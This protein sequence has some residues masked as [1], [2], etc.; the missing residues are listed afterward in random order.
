MRTALFWVITQ[1]VVV[2]SYRGFGKN[3]QSHLQG[4]KFLTG[5]PETPVRNYHYSLHTQPRRAQVIFLFIGTEN[6]LR[7]VEAGG[8]DIAE[9]R[10]YDTTY[11]N[12][13][14]FAL[15]I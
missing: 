15:M 9:H 4:S 14:L 10:T 3:S 5:S 6:F 1:P 8:E 13:I 7:V 11:H 2:I 12:Q